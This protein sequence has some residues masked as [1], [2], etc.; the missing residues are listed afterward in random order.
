LAGT[1]VGGVLNLLYGDQQR[2]VKVAM[3]W[4]ALDCL[5]RELVRHGVAAGDA[6]VLHRVLTFWGVE[7]Y[8][9]RLQDGSWMA[10]DRLVLCF[11]C[12]PAGAEPRRLLQRCGLLPPDAA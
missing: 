7:E 6:T 2:T 4:D 9:R 8:G 5:R 1:Q 3:S 10:G 11:G 12:G